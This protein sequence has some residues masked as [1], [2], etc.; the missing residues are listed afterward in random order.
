MT[1]S[2]PPKSSPPKSSIAH[3]A[4]RTLRQYAIIFVYLYVCFGALVLH[5][6]AV[7]HDAGIGYAPWGFAAVKAF[8]L[9]SSC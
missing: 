1:S 7:L 6:A 5:K 3:R 4:G 8:I 2:V 9:A